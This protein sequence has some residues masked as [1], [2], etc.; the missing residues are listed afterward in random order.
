LATAVTVASGGYFNGGKT[1]ASSTTAGFFLGYDTGIAQFAIGDATT[2]MKWNG[3]NLL[4]SGQTVNTANLYPQTATFSSLTTALSTG[5]IYYN[6]TPT[7]TQAIVSG[8]I[9]IPPATDVS[10]S[11]PVCINFFS[12]FAGFN[13]ARSGAS[14]L[15]EISWRIKRTTIGPGTVSYV[16][17]GNY[18]VDII[19]VVLARTTPI[20][21]QFIDNTTASATQYTYAVEFALTSTPTNSTVDW[22]NIVTPMSLLC[23]IYKK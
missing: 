2:S 1:N 6:S 11:P 22:V 15:I 3:Y 5:N 7:Y 20:N 10:P 18:Q 13:V 12:V 17:M 23:N 4:L 8:G 19:N 9:M 21:I 16:Y 14:S